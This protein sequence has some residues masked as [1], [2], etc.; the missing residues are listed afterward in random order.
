MLPLIK[1]S[2]S[3]KL[4]MLEFSRGKNE[5]VPHQESISGPDGKVCSETLFAYI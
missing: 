4:F 2:D 3:S 1:S 5:Y